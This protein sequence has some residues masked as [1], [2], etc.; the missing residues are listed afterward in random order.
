[1][2]EPWVPFF[3]Q[4]LLEVCG[5]IRSHEDDGDGGREHSQSVV[6]GSTKGS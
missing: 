2:P 5:A 1:V 6:L 3:C 4:F